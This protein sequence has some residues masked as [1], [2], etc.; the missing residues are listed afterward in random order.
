VKT[1]NRTLW[2]WAERDYGFRF[3]DGAG[4]RANELYQA[5]KP[6][7]FYTIPAGQRKFDKSR[8]EELA[9]LIS[10]PV[11]PSIVASPWH[12]YGNS[13]HQ[14]ITA[15]G[16]EPCLNVAGCLDTNELNE[17]ETHGVNRAKE[18]ILDLAG[19]ETPAPITLDLIQR[20]HK[21]MF[22]AIYPWA[23][24]WRTVSLHKGDGPTKWPLPP[25]GMEPVMEDF[26][27]KVLGQTPFI[28]NDDDAVI[29]FLAQF[30]GDY[31]ALHPFREGNGRSAFILGDLILLQNGLATL[32]SYNRK[33]DEVRYFAACDAGRLCD[34]G[35]LAALLTEWQAERQAIL[36]QQ[37]GGEE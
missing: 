31:L 26:A 14:R 20:V 5:A 33:R 36:A 11:A 13:D 15:H 28:S 30:L 37:L 7:E 8:M 24:Q 29:S 17:R 34:Y 9:A 22:G 6:G 27:L 32:D 1:P 19:R 23:S 3:K 12:D 35:P 2:R 18:F 10:A 4:K 25:F 21:D 16:G